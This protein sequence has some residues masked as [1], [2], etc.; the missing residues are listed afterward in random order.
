MH[1][2]YRPWWDT[3]VHDIVPLPLMPPSHS[4]PLPAAAAFAL[5][6]SYDVGGDLAGEW[7]LAGCPDVCLPLLLGHKAWPGQC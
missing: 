3:T 1:A 4:F 2:Q 7:G 5:C 6:K